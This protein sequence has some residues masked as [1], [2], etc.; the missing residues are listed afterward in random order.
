[1]EP[2]H[3]SRDSRRAVTLRRVG[4]SRFEAVNARGGTIRFGQGEDADFTPVELLL[5]AT[6]GCSGID[7]DILT[8]RR[9]EPESF[10]VRVEG[11][12]VRDKHG[13]H[14]S[15]IEVTFRVRFPEGEDGDRAREVLPDAA[16]RSHE[17]LCTVTRSLVLSTP[18]SSVVED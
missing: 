7:V 18:V 16:R 12:K 13:N 5:A 10:E 8:S 11:D 15:G 4:P 14:L 1:M 3:A 2:Q 6:G 9:A 17:R